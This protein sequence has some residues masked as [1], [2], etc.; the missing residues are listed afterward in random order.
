MDVVAEAEIGQNH[1]FIDVAQQLNISI[2]A[3]ESLIHFNVGER[4]EE[5][6]VIAQRTG[7]IPQTIRAPMGG[8]VVTVGAGLVMLDVGEG[9]FELRAGYPGAV[10]RVFPERGVEISVTG[11]LVQGVWGNGRIDSGLMLPLLSQPEDVLQVRQIDVSLRGSVVLAGYLNDTS[12]L[13]AGS[14]L[15]LRGLIL[16]NISPALIPAALQVRYPVIVI[17]GFVHSPMN[18]AA[19]KLLTTNAKREAAINAQSYDR[20]SGTRPE[21]IIPLP[22]SQE[23]PT[24]RDVDI[25]APNQQVRICRA[26]CPGAIGTLVNLLPGLTAF[27]NGLRLEA[28]EVQLHN[29]DQVV[30]PL[31]N[32]ELVG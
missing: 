10:T 11:A 20:Y 14:E 9:T 1:L 25:F 13:Q 12:V 21:L 26:P 22:V 4:I 31:V 18:M 32:L 28:A 3:A 17:D 30:I 27:P 5:N 29:G 2:A 6:Q 23:P 24:P 7:I 19:F 16:A 15:P 8:R